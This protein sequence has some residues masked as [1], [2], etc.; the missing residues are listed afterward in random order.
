MRGLLHDTLS[1]HILHLYVCLYS[2]IIVLQL[3]GVYR[4]HIPILFRRYLR[5]KLLMREFEIITFIH[6]ARAKNHYVDSIANH[7]LD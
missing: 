3:N 4:V 5:V 2:L 7:I 1:D 6:L